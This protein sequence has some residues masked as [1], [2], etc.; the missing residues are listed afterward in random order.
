MNLRKVMI[1][2]PPNFEFRDHKSAKLS[3][4]DLEGAIRWISKHPSLLLKFSEIAFRRIDFLESSIW[5]NQSLRSSIKGQYKLEL[6]HLESDE[7]PVWENAL[8]WAPKAA[9][10][11][12]NLTIRKWN[13]EQINR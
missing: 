9:P 5:L 12:I 2:L 3:S 4:Y 8:R 10:K 6:L 1:P 11:L 13:N 7:K